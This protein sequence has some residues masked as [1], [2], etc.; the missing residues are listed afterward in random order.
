MAGVASIIGVASIMGSIIGV[1]VASIIGSAMPSAALSAGSYFLQPVRA[2][3]PGTNIST[4]IHVVSFFMTSVL[5]RS[6]GLKTP[7]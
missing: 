5:P 4:S 2:R 3:S 6:N 7:A 1:G